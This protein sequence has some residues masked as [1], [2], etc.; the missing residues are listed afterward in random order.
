MIPAQGGF[1]PMV[2]P[3]T[4]PAA[5]SD[6]FR[7]TVQPTDATNPD[8]PPNSDGSPSV[9]HIV[10]SEPPIP[11]AASQYVGPRQFVQVGNFD[12]R[13]MLV[14][15]GLHGG[16]STGFNYESNVFLGNGRTTAET[17]AASY[18]VGAN[19]TFRRGGEDAYE[20]GSQNSIAITYNVGASFYGD[21]GIA[22]EVNHT[23]SLDA[24]LTL[25]KLTLGFN[26]QTNAF[27]DG[28]VGTSR[29]GQYGFY[30]SDLNAS[31][32]WTEKI[33]TH[34]DAILSISSYQD[35]SD[36]YDLSFRNVAEH[37]ITEKL[38][39]GVGFTTGWTF[40]QNSSSQPYQQFF[41][42]AHFFNLRK[43]QADFSIG[44]EF[45]ELPGGSSVNVVYIR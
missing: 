35:S 25:N 45:R 10:P 21:H 13:Q 22:P 2:A 36:S 23:L 11:P 19:I 28:I 39:L 43:L 18:Y 7:T 12:A 20:Q 4:A 16:V 8:F 30:T 27:Y 15:Y 31:Y 37:A 9:V 6:L 3:N 41:V 40:V 33:T 29:R 1:S 38:K 14:G 34:H 32:A 26:E 5:T 42:T 24:H 17:S 44:P